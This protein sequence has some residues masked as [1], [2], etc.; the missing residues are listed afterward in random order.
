MLIVIL[1]ILIIL[2]LCFY[3]FEKFTDINTD[4]ILPKYVWGYWDNLELNSII[5]SHINTWKRKIPKDWRIII[6]NKENYHN[7]VSKEFVN[8]YNDLNPTHFSDFLRLE[9]LQ[10]YGGVWMDAS[11]II[12]DG[13][14][15]NKYYDEMML[16]KYDATI[17][18]LKENTV[19]I[20]TPYLENW[21]IM[22]PKNSKYINDIYKEFDK[23]F[24]MDFLTYKKKIL[25]P[26]GVRL[27]K[28][29]GYYEKTYLMQHAIINFLML[30]NYKYNLNIKDSYKSMFK[31]HNDKNW[32]HEK[33]IDYIQENKKWDDY[34]GI[35]LTK[36][37]RVFINDP[38]KYVENINKI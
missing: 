30:K 5:Q 21:F 31:I 12:T 20:K 36:H 22:A 24:D 29:L 10:K 33:V 27:D 3:N 26:S 1:F 7:Y 17:Y 38:K 37:S 18:E 35:K 19:D 9:L 4:Y 25:I 28:T 6:L 14:F 8:K 23:A 16:N 11:I 32:D 13:N 34:Y 2:L 15:L